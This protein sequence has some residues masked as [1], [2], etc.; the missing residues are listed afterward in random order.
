LPPDLSPRTAVRIADAFADVRGIVRV[1][2]GK[3]D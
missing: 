1:F 2:E 3:L